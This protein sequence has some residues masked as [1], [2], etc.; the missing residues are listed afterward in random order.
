MDN[1]GI[2]SVLWTY[3]VLTLIDLAVTLRL[4][5]LVKYLEANPAYPYIGIT[6][7]MI[8]NLI[9]ILVV[10]WYYKTSKNTL[11]RF[12]MMNCMVTTFITKIIVII[13]NLKVAMRPPTIYQAMQVT[14]TMK[15]EQ[16]SQAAII[17]I[18]PYIIAVVVFLFYKLDHEVNV[19]QKK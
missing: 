12:L 3:L 19:K 15:L 18:F 14:Q 9:V 17:A 5:P 8:I 7:I 16:V 11:H 2:K 13:N 10:Y 1:V 4:G 6:G